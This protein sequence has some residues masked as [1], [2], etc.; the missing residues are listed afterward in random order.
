MT[1][2]ADTNVL[3]YRVDPRNRRKQEIA[4]AL[5]RSG[6][7]TGEIV[8]THQNLLEFVRAVTKPIRGIGSLL[9]PDAALREAEDLMRQFD[10]LFPNPSVFRTAL[11]GALAYQM[12]WFDAHL[13]AYAE[14][15]GIPTIYS[16]DFQHGRSYGTVLVTDPFREAAESRE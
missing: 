3:V 15:F 2:I 10:V 11:R 9:A 12:S 16:E 6:I 5:L 14:V 1:A 13:W 8:L 4:T 7:E